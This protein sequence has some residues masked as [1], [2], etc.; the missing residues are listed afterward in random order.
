MYFDQ[1]LVTLSVDG[2]VSILE[3]V[4]KQ[5]QIFFCP[6]DTDLSVTIVL[7]VRYSLLQLMTNHGTYDLSI[8]IHLTI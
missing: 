1:V 5:K 4:R 2:I 8:R 7:L 6:L 3:K